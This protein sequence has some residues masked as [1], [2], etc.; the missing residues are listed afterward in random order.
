LIEVTKLHKSY[1]ATGV[2]R[3]IDLST[4]PGASLALLGPNGAGKTT[5]LRIISTL[6]RPDTGSVTVNSFDTAS[7]GAYVRQV[8]GVV[9]HSP[10][11]Y[12]ELTVGENL[13]FFAKMFQLQNPEPRIKSLLERVEMDRRIET[14]VRHLSHGQQKRVALARALLHSPRTLILDEPESGLDQRSRNVLAGIIN[15]YRAPGRSVIMTTHTLDFGLQLADSVAMLERG[16][17]A[18][19]ET[20]TPSTIA[21]LRKRLGDHVRETVG[22]S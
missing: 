1:G 6:T 21:N 19:L 3:G 18:T 10:M 4:Q 11:L 2:L 17:V 22:T 7:Q 8:T 14:R 16:T 12:G 9:M 5:L 15:E 20:V 13:R